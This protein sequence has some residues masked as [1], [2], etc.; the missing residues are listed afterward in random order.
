MAWKPISLT[1]PESFGALMQ[2]EQPCRSS[3]GDKVELLQN[4]ELLKAG[5]HATVLWAA[6]VEPLSRRSATARRLFRR[7]VDDFIEVLKNASASEI[8]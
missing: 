7:K 4:Y 6:C 3:S 8:P 1:D 2:T 5:D